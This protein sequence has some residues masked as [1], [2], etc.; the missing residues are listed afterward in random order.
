MADTF[1]GYV[2]RDVDSQINWAEIGKNLTDTLNEEVRVREEKKA[3]IDKATRDYSNVLANAPQG[4]HKGMN[5]YTLTYADNAQKARLLQDR[6]LKSG[7][8]DLR[9]YNV[10]RQNLLDGTDQAFTLVNDYQTEYSDKMERAK[11]GESQYLEQFLMASAEGFGNFNDTELYINPTDYTVSIGKKVKKTIDGKEVITMSDNPNDFTTVNAMRNRIKGKYDA[12][13]VAGSLE[14]GVKSL[15]SEINVIRQ[16]GKETLAGSLT[17]VLDITKR[18]DFGVEAQ[19]AISLYER[20]EDTYLDSLLSNPLNTS[21][22]LTN[23]VNVNPN[24]KETFDYTWDPKEVDGNTIL[25][26]NDASGNPTPEFTKEQREIA[27]NALREKFRLMLDRE[28]KVDTYQEPTRERI[29]PRDRSQWEYEAAQGEKTAQNMTNMLGSLWGGDD[30]EVSSAIEYFQGMPGVKRVGRNSQGVS[31]TYYDENQ[32]KDVTKYISFYANGKLKNQAEF[33]KAAGPA[34]ASQYDINTALEKGSFNQG[35]EFNPTFT[36][37]RQSKISGGK[38][39]EE[40]QRASFNN[41]VASSLPKGSFGGDEDTVAA[42]IEKKFG[43]FGVEVETTGIGSD[44]VTVSLY[45]GLTDSKGNSLE[46]TVELNLG[47]TPSERAAARQK[48]E[49]WLQANVSDKKISQVSDAGG[50]KTSSKK[51]SSGGVKKFN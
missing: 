24:T 35:R 29:Q 13:D 14:G 4:E 43:R 41:Y 5:Q 7:Q 48:L 6:L 37:A 46:R 33:I 25:L 11:N 30:T 34:F 39:T 18:K 16:L 10:M 27:K 22:I 8:L 1:Y 47:G 20:A 26:R 17:E 42:Y 31:I 44:I 23:Y 40:N 51:A 12:F 28:E 2:E 32:K 38:D 15:G 45:K 50:L 3:A 9:Q 19:S 21:S 49:G 36:G